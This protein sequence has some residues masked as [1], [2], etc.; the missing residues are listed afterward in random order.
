M[1]SPLRSKSDESKASPKAGGAWPI[2]DWNIPALVVNS[3]ELA[4]ELFTV[5]DAAISAL[6]KSTGAKLLA[7]DFVTFGFFPSNEY[8]R[9]M[10]KLT[11]EE[12]LSSRRLEQLKY[13]RAS[14]VEGSLKDL[15]KFWEKNKDGANKALVEMKKWFNDI[16]TNVILRMVLGKRYFGV[17]AAPDE[18]KA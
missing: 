1:E 17:S 12:L 14:E 7:Y 4:K 6:P 3:W 15:Y 5:H 9:E 11:A 13:I 2:I 16:N 18:K 10:R 8:W